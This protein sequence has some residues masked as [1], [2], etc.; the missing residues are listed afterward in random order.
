MG[1]PDYRD[2]RVPQSNG[3]KLVMPGFNGA[4]PGWERK[5]TLRRVCGPPV[6]RKE[7]SN[8]HRAYMSSRMGAK[9]QINALVVFAS[10]C[11]RLSARI[12]RRSR[13]SNPTFSSL[14]R[15][16]CRASCSQRILPPKTRHWTPALRH[17]CSEDVYAKSSRGQKQQYDIWVKL[18]RD[19]REGSL[20]EVGIYTRADGEANGPTFLGSCF[21]L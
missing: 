10:A 16:V 11:P 12:A 14:L 8:R 3:G 18:Y 7:R 17:V 15:F 5:G 21:F 2:G 4:A 9:R 13:L 1:R 19:F 20:R 6:P